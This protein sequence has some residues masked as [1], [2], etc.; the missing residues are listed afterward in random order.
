[1]ETLTGQVSGTINPLAY[2]LYRT[3]DPL[4]KGRSTMA[5]DFVQVD[6][7]SVLDG[8]S[9]PSSS[10]VSVT[11]ESHVILSGVEYLN[12]LGANPLSVRVFNADK[13][14]EYLSP[15]ASASPDYTFIEGDQTTPLGIKTTDLSAI[16]QGQSLL[17]DYSHDENYTVVYSPNV[18]IGVAQSAIEPQRHI[19]A[20]V[21][22]KEALPVPVDITATVVVQN[23]QDT[24]RSVAQIDSDVRTALARHFNALQM[25]EPVRPADI[26][27]VIDRVQGVS[28]PIHPLTKVVKGEGAPVIREA[29]ATSQTAD[30][31]EV[32]EW[33]TPT[34]KVWLLKDELISATTHAGGP[35]T[36]FRAV[37][38]SDVR[39]EHYEDAPNINGLPLNRSLSSCFIIGDGGLTIPGFSDDETLLATFV[40]DDDPDVQRDQLQAKRRELTK[41]RVLVTLPNEPNAPTPRDF[42]YDVTYIVG[43]DT[44]TKPVEPGT[45]AYLVLGNVDLTFDEDYDFKARVLGRGN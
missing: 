31:Y 11:D 43:E 23:S 41:N 36:E 2:N 3:A 9:V 14:V 45:A 39:L 34:V 26:S 42:A 22:V 32:T 27:R 37:H 4:L 35:K 12:F 38:A 33:G 40:F 16:T 6:D 10:P 8:L 44:G 15:Y 30:S 18:L 17:I 7:S 29:L 21:L 19:T 13:S 25:G 28:Y 1:V 20:D 5:S 24:V